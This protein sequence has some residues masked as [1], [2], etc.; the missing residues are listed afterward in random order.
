MVNSLMSSRKGV[1]SRHIHTSD[2]FFADILGAIKIFNFGSN[3][4]RKLRDIKFGHWGNPRLP[5][6]ESRPEIF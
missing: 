1:D 3:S 4:C 5:F 6:F 2:L